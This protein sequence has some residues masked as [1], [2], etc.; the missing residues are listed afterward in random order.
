MMCTIE[1]LPYVQI[2]GVFDIFGGVSTSTFD[3]NKMVA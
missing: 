3:V 1:V 2:N